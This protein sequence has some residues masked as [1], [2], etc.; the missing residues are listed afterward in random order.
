LAQ[1]RL[2][3]DVFKDNGAGLYEAAGGDGAMLGVENWGVW[4]GRILRPGRRGLGAALALGK[5]MEAVT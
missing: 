1:A 2:F 5:A 3:A 4:T